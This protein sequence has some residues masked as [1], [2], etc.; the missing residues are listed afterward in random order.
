VDTS[1]SF[2][3]SEGFGNNGWSLSPDGNR[4]AV[5]MTTGSGEDIWIKELPRGPLSRLTFDSVPEQRPRWTRDGRLVTYIY[6]A[7]PSYLLE[8][9]SDGSGAVGKIVTLDRPILEGFRSADN[10]WVIMRVGGQAARRGGRDI[11]GIRPGI[12]SIPLPL[13]ADSNADETS[14]QLSPD[15][16]W[17]AYVSDE[18]GSNEVYVRPF[19]NISG[20][21]WQVSNNGGQAPLWAH[22]GRELFYVDAQRNMVAV[23][24]AGGATPGL[25]THRRLF[26]LQPE[27]YLGSPE[28][29]TPFDIAPDD[30]RFLMARQ[31]RA[32]SRARPGEFVVIENWFEELITRM[33]EGKR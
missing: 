1:W 18:T 32:A 11:V 7:N 10:A 5:N 12:D 25:G 29:Y 27:I 15:G 22:S 19:P 30:Q 4:V 26:L 31:V 21:Q 16:R 8:R 24:V 3:L 13:V 6:L 9:Q 33:E 23:P 20:G 14:P 28:R 2:R 17:L